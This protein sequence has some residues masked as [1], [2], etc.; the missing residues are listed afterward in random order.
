MCEED[1]DTVPRLAQLVLGHLRG[2]WD[3]LEIENLERLED[4]R[5]LQHRREP[6]Q[7]RFGDL[8][9]RQPQLLGLGQRLTL[10]YLAERL[11]V[12]VVPIKLIVDVGAARLEPVLV[13]RCVELSS[14]LI[15]IGPASRKRGGPSRC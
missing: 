10:E 12:L 7:A 3:A 1:L 15:V 2:L 9:V 13:A 11:D 5:L 14:H 6:G 8:V 4:F